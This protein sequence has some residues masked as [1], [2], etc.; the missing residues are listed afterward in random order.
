MSQASRP[1]TRGLSRRKAM[2]WVDDC[3]REGVPFVLAFHGGRAIV[4]EFP[5]GRN[6]AAEAVVDELRSRMPACPKTH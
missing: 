1:T 2:R 6:D 5:P 4:Y 3:I